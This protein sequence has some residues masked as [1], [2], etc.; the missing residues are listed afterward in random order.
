MLQDTGSKVIKQVRGNL[1]ATPND[2][3]TKQEREETPGNMEARRRRKEANS[4]S[5]TVMLAGCVQG[6]AD[7]SRD[8]LKIHPWGE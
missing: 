4:L 3:E 7:I 1:E 6:F 5:L 8:E 2:T